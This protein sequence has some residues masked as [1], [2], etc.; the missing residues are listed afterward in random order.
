MQ[1]LVAKLSIWAEVLFTE[2][3]ALIPS[4]T[5][6]V[7][8][9]WKGV[10]STS[11]TIFNMSNSILV[12]SVVEFPFKQGDRYLVH[13][14][15]DTGAL[16]TNRCYPTKLLDEAADDLR[17]LGPPVIVLQPEPAQRKGLWTLPAVL[18]LLVL[19]LIVLL[20]RSQRR[21]R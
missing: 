20:M 13:A 8:D 5:F 1:F 2:R 19:P 11:T 3:S 17:D 7:T 14:N 6:E 10:T 15:R 21:L 4:V 12:A 9:S 16:V 18:S